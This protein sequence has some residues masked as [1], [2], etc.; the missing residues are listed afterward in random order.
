MF[1]THYII[2]LDGSGLT[3]YLNRSGKA[4]H[5]KG[6]VRHGA[7]PK[8]F[9]TLK[10]AFA[11]AKSL[12]TRLVANNQIRPEDD[13]NIHVVEVSYRPCNPLLPDGFYKP[14]HTKVVTMKH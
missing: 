13:Q 8:E 2:Q 6:S 11:R 3:F 10:G 4:F 7:V 9:K 1:K 14:V 12:Y 5:V